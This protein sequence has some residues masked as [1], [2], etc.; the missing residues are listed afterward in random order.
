M[1][2]SSYVDRREIINVDHHVE[3]IVE[4]AIRR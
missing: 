3:N 4:K 1:L 2:T